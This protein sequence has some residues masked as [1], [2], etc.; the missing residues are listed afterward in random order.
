MFG[1]IAAG[2]LVQLESEQVA[3]NRF[4]FS[5]QDP[6]DLNH[7]VAFMTGVTP[8]PMGMGASVYF[9]YKD[10]SG[11]EMDWQL[12]GVLSNDKPSAIFRVAGLKPKKAMVDQPAMGSMNGNFT[13]HQLTTFNS[14]NSV[15]PVTGPS[16]AQIGISVE[17]L[18]V[19]EQMVIS[20][21]GTPSSV[22]SVG[23]VAAMS[24]KLMTNLYD[25]L[26]SFAKAGVSFGNAPCVPLA[27]VDKWRDLLA[28]KVER[29]PNFL[30]T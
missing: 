16:V 3:E 22:V 23:S 1:V 28:K 25:Y 8:F 24:G 9:C 17:P 2:R 19:I 14:F 15:N 6:E 30:K 27:V 20:K 4:V 21:G 18:E 5:I 29:D 13:G 11:T 26:A 12:L 7:I 10:P